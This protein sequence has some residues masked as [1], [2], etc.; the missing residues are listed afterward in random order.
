[1]RAASAFVSAQA[2]VDITAQVWDHVKIRERAE[3][4]PRVIVGQGSY[5]G[6]GVQIG[7]DSKVQNL[8][9]IYEPAKI[10]SGVF[11]GPSVIL[12]NDREP[13]AV[14]PEFVQK[15]SSDWIPVGVTVLD[16]A[17][18]GAGA[19][20]VAPVTVGRWAM[21]AAGSVVVRDV[22][23]FALVVGNPARQVG[24]VGRA[25][26]RLIQT[27][28]GALHWRCPQTD[29]KYFQTDQG[30]LVLEGESPE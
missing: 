13:R 4:G 21:V 6:P 25:G 20:C 15:T 23:N 17:S 7:A 19:V 10:G 24:W 1:M 30:I 2:R 3:I 28:G 26:R 27:G 18:I 16:A 29:E 14:N 5:I 22:P 11:I 12:T 8:A 9:Q